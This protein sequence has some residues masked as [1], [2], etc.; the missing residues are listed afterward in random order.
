MKR[1][2]SV[3]ATLALLA[4][5]L[6]ALA[7]TFVV[8]RNDDPA[9]NGCLPGDCSL[10][11]A[12]ASAN[13]NANTDTIQVPPGQFGLPRGGLVITGSVTIS[14]SFDPATD[15]E[16]NG[17]FPVFDIKGAINVNLSNLRLR[18]HGAHAVN[19]EAETHTILGGIRIPDSD[20]QVWV[21]ESYNS[22]GSLDIDSSDIH[23]YVDCGNIALCRVTD[24]TLLRLQA[25]SGSN[26]LIDVE[27]ALSLIDGANGD[28]GAVVQTNGSVSITDTT[29]RDTSI[30]LLFVSGSPSQV[31]LDHL[32]YSGNRGPLDV[33]VQ[34]PISLI[35]SEFSG[36]VNDDINGGPGA[37]HASG[38][39]N[40][41]IAN[42]SFI[43]NTGNGDVGGA[44]LVE[45]DAD[46][47][48]RNSTFSAN[49]FSA[50]SAAGARGATIGYIADDGVI[51]V[52]LAHV[53]IVP[54]A[55]APV[56]ILGSALGGIGGDSFHLNLDVINSIV[57][58]TC[59]LDTGAMDINLGNIESPGD[60]CQFNP[61]YN[62]VDVTS[63]A[64][65]LGTL[66]DH[67]GAT[68]TYVPGAAS[69][70]IDQ[71]NALECLDTDQRG[72]QRPFG[73]GCDVGAVERGAEDRVFA[74]GFD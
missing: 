7:E 59:S 20:S 13:A 49:T 4:L 73:N 71:A 45:K 40:W 19:A 31:S 28:S 55:F 12:L 66:G 69:V 47:A 41:Q 33:R 10:R 54:A 51:S 53:T 56:G 21:G 26:S 30:G 8:T 52:S 16:G 36:N 38:G 3:F 65:G 5:S 34:S 72:Y 74:D 58:G 32:T 67:G 43:G 57:R 42:S 18:A 11:E 44:V 24:S 1:R 2:L 62:L 46:V 25:G 37:I 17:E 27:I 48:I 64:L 22:G 14:G 61:N 6:P 23:A 9:P 29:I 50:G 39:S 68:R 70:A 35:D 60:T 63:G 15:V